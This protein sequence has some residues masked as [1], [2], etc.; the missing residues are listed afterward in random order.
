MQFGAVLHAR[1]TSC[2]T[3]VVVIHADYESQYRCAGFVER[4]PSPLAI[5]DTLTSD[6]IMFSVYTVTRYRTEVSWVPSDPTRERFTRIFAWNGS[7]SFP[8]PFLP[9]CAL[10]QSPQV[11][12]FKLRGRIQKFPDWLDNKINK[13]NNKHSLRSNTQDCGSKLCCFSTSVCCCFCLFCYRVSPET[14]WYTLV[15]NPTYSVRLN[16]ILQ[17][18][19][20][21][22]GYVVS[23]DMNTV[24]NK[25]GGIWVAMLYQL[26]RLCSV[27][28]YDMGSCSFAPF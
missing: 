17:C 21:C 11:P 3:S 26:L 9:T 19:I 25:L 28:W 16:I 14:F 8:A 24:I 13:I 1:N 5:R 6:L 15:L 23:N 22:W 12:Y 4:S 27:K 20:N 2:V 18:Y 7:R 10:N